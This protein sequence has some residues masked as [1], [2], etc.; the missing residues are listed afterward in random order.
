ML[1]LIDFFEHCHF[2]R[3]GAVAHRA[4][5]HLLLSPPLVYTYLVSAPRPW[6]QLV[7]RF[8][9]ELI[10]PWRGPAKRRGGFF[11]GS[12]LRFSFLGY[13]ILYGQIQLHASCDLFHVSCV[14][15]AVIFGPLTLEITSVLL[16][17]MNS[18]P[19]CSYCSKITR[20]S[21]FGKASSLLEN[22]ILKFW[23]FSQLMKIPSH[24]IF[25]IFLIVHD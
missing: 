11:K 19:G 20:I 18:P 12:K 25:L 8:G 5:H 1:T 6:Q 2:R 4:A 15:P 21:Q 14:P 10:T 7:L 17:L 16:D 23:H 9:W 13:F 3:Y 22:I 24:N